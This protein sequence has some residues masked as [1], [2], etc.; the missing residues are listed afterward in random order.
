MTNA[1]TVNTTAVEVPVGD[2][3]P[4]LVN[5]GT[6]TVYFGSTAAV[7]TATGIPLGPGIGYEFPETL[8]EAGWEALWVIGDG[9]GGQIR[10]GTVG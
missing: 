5:S 9:A 3:L 7:T 6:T 2:R 1:L 10:Y 8:R 4:V